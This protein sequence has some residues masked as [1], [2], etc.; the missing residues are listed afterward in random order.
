MIEEIPISAL[1][2]RQVKQLEGADKVLNSNP[3]YAKEIYSAVVKLSPGCLD[4]R[5]KLRALQFRLNPNS[6]KGLSGIFGK[7]NSCTVYVSRERR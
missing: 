4:V 1:D 2:P 7:G 3:N 6:S 5:R